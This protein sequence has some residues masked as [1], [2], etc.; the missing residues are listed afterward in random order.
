MTALVMHLPLV[1]DILGSL[2]GVI[3]ADLP[4]YRNH[5]YRV[6]NLCYSTGEYDADSHTKIQ[7][8]A[9]FH[10]VGIWTASTLDYLPP[11]EWAAQRY[12]HEHG[13]DD[14]SA[15]ITAMIA[16]HHA[17]TPQH[18]AGQAL[19]E[20]FRRADIADFSLGTVR[21]G[22]AR[23]TVQAVRQAFPNAGFHRRLLQ[24]GVRW[25]LRHP[26]NPLPMFRW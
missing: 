15:E 1:E 23:D 12:L 5:V 26:L 19:V 9:C 21:M 16:Q 25:T 4:A 20:A 10:D 11:S 6:I 3:G 8:A 13:L 22:I 7:I 24:L 2:Q 17:L 18:G 14:W